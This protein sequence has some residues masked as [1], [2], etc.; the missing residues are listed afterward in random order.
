M[1]FDHLDEDQ[2]GQIDVLEF[3]ELNDILNLQ[4]RWRRPSHPWPSERCAVPV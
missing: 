1:L 4:A 3:F 2:S